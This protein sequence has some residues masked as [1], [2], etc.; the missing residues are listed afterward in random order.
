MEFDFDVITIGAGVIG[1]AIS[2]ELSKRNLKVV[3]LEK[4]LRIAQ[5]TSEGNSG[6]IHG[7]F[8]PTPGKLNA[9]LNL[10]GRKL[11]ENDWFKNLD[12][13][14]KK[15]DSLILAFSKEENSEI[16][17]LYARGITNGLAKKELS[18]LTREEVISLEPNVNPKVTSA[19]LCSASYAVD[20]V[21]LTQ[22][23]INRMI[24][25]RGQLKVDHQVINIETLNSGFRVTCLNNQKKVTFTSKY[26]I[27]AAG[28]YADDIAKLINCQDFTLKTRRGQYCILEKTENHIIN[29]HILFMI[30]TINGKGVIVAPMLD[31]HI[32]VGPTSHENVPKSDTRLIT[33]EDIEL[34]NKIGLKIIPILNINKTCKVIS[35]SRAICVETDDFFIK[36]AS[37]NT[38]FINVAGIKSPGLSS[39]PTI[40]LLVANMIKN[41]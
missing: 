6:V 19:L 24:K 26:I 41:I 22:S 15:I 40:A 31:G 1:A 9:K 17:K 10:E 12:F 23:L 7:G 11:Y 21:L 37:N 36:F 14:W 20:P 33:I 25:N 2:D 30:P 3:I 8:D 13:P 28:D 29:N 34:I 5:E 39:A 38:N 27:N 16:Q 4:N 18:I 32:L 35:G